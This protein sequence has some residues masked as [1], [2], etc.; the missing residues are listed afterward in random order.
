YSSPSAPSSANPFFSLY[1]CDTIC[2]EQTILSGGLGTTGLEFLVSMPLSVLSAQEG[3]SLTRI[4]AFTALADDAAEAP[5][6]FDQANLPDATI[7]NHQ[8]LLGIA[9]EG[10]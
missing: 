1:R 10:T 8:V 7:P 5:A 4:Q 6:T 2:R 9:P 3:A